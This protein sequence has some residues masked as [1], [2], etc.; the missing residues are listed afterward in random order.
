MDISNMNKE[1]LEALAYRL[2]VQRQNVNQNLSVVEQQI[3]KLAA[4]PPTE[5]PE[6]EEVIVHT[7]DENESD[8]K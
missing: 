4:E 3:Q 8:E 5:T 2:V 7:D 1:Q 6:G